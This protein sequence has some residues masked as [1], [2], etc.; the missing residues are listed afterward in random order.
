MNSDIAILMACYNAEQT[1]KQAIDSILVQSHS[2]FIFIIVD[3]GSQDQSWNIVQSYAQ[4][5][6]RILNVRNEQNIGLAGSLNR[7]L[8]LSQAKWI[9]RMDADDWSYPMRLEK[10]LKFVAKN[11]EIDILGCGIE[12]IDKQ[13][14]SLGNRFLKEYHDDIIKDLFKKPL[15]YHPSILIRR[16]IFELYGSYDSKLKW[17][18][19]SD[20]WYRIYDKVKFHNLPEVLLKY[21]VKDSLNLKIIKNNLKV[22]YQNLKRRS[23]LYSHGKFLVRDLFIQSFKLLF[24]W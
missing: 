11:P 4:S 9:M 20:L 19:D 15:V 14:V 10:Q 23:M 16:S 17:A 22:K 2:N 5:D 24:R 8:Q 1:L 18:E 21:R 6:P 7:G 3:D 12:C 13:G